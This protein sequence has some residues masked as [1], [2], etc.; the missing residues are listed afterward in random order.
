MFEDLIKRPKDLARYQ[1][2]PYVEERQRFLDHIVQEGRGRWRLT[3]LNRL[4]LESAMLIDL[5]GTHSYSIR[6]LQSVA[7]QWQRDRESKGVSPRWAKRSLQ[8][9]VFVA[10]SWLRFLGRLAKPVETLRDAGFLAEFLAHLKEERGYAEATI[11]N[12]RAS[13]KP[14]L[15]WLEEK[16]VRMSRV[17][18][19]TISAYFSSAAAG[20]WKRNSVSLHVQSLRAFFRYAG[21]RGWCKAGIAESIDAPRL[22]TYESLPQGPSWAEVN[23]LLAG[24]SGRSPLQLRSRCVVLLCAVYG[25]RIGE[26]SRL[27]L[28]DIDWVAEKISVHRPKQRKVQT[29][30]LTAEAGNVLLR[31]LRFARPACERREILLTLRQPYR[32]V[33]ID[34]LSCMVARLEKKLGLKLKRFGPHALRHACATHL[35]AQGLTM[36]EVGDHLGHVSVVAT[37]IYAKVDLAGLR[38]VASLD[39]KSLVACIEQC[40]QSAAPF[41]AVGD[42]Q[43]LRAVAGIGLGGVA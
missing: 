35:L 11:V 22:Y 7:E 37:R 10:S 4:L 42:I 33:S 31:Y 12:R 36:K 41:Y 9:F 29:Y 40:E 6:A 13:L 17:A 38:A 2:G 26:V 30:P 19:A 21:S 8:D 18:P 24:V 1:S 25:L 27:R 15:R 28:D 14:F 16:G 43:A 20:R 3:V 23:R 5:S 32:P 34:G 39:L